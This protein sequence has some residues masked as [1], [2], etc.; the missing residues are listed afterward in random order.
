M[1]GKAARRK[2]R[3]AGVVVASAAF[4]ASPKLLSAWTLDAAAGF[5]TARRAPLGISRLTR[6]DFADPRLVL[7]DDIVRRSEAAFAADGVAQSPV[8]AQNPPQRR[9]AIPAGPLATVIAAFSRASGITVTFALD[10][11]DAIQSPGVAGTFTVEQALTRLLE[12]LGLAFRFTSS[13]AITIDLAPLSE[14]VDVT[15]RATGAAVSLPKYTQPLRDIPQTIEVIPREVMEAQGVTTLSEALR[16]VPGITMQAGEGGAASNTSGDMFNMRGFNAANS[17]FVDGVRDDGLISRDV[18]NLEQVEVFMGPTGSD[19]GRSTA[20]GYVNMQ[21]KAPHLPNA[22]SAQVNF[23]SSDRLRMSVDANRALRLGSAGS[24]WNKSA[25]RFNALWQDVGVPGRDLVELDSVG[26]APSIAFGLETPTRLT[27]AAQ[28][29]KQDNVPDYGVP[30]SAWTEQPLTPTTVLAPAPV[31]QRN[32]YGSPAF[33]Y[34]NATQQSYTARVERDVSPRLTLRNQT[35]YNQT[36]REA[37]ITS[38]GNPAAYNPAT[39]LVTLSRQGNER[40]NSIFSNQT[41]AID[42]F[43][44]GSL[45]HAANAGIEFTRE[46]QFAPGLTG[47]GTRAPV[48]IFNPNPND[49]VT[50][51]AVARTGASNDG[52]SNTFALYAFDTVD[53]GRQWQVTGGARWEYYDVTYLAVDALGNH[54]TDAQAS[55]AIVSGKIG[56]LYKIRPEGNLYVSYG[57]TVTPPGSANFTLSAQQNNQNNPNVEPQ[58]SRNFEIGS[59]WDFANGRVSMNTAVFR[60][61]NTNV[62]YTIDAT[63]VPPIYNQDDGQQVDGFTIGASGQVLRQWQVMAN[64]AFLDT[65]LESQNPANNGNRLTLTPRFSGSVWTTYRLPHRISIGGGLRATD[66]VFINAAN[67]ISSPGYRLVDALA[68][69]EVNQHLT[70][71]LNVYN[72]TDAVYIRNVNNNGGRYNPGNPRS[73]QVTSGF[74]F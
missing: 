7:L 17:L 37:V 72:L 73:V 4:A 29:V 9:Y 57:T 63:A 35:R 38:I 68:E 18:F 33:D 46:R 55:D 47:V 51:Y 13:D 48:D 34:D 53:L 61:R 36:H 11:L 24:W 10:G 12:G 69:Y 56:L 42:R 20:A 14:S 50:D 59:K 16:N 26:V 44:T 5:D 74:R 8:A 1:T 2:L 22:S 19:I 3:K 70:L 71:R 32:Y 45:R 43:S 23:G 30:G 52:V 31:S 6:S 60:T 27:V 64:F 21:T 49:A 39:N 25:V 28:I 66:D 67:T 58:E 65:A 62:I 40:E 54:T 15:G 41:G